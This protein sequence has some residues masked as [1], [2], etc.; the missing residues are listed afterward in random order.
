MHKPFPACFCYR[1]LPYG[2][3]IIIIII[4]IIIRQF[5]KRRGSAEAEGKGAEQNLDKS[6]AQKSSTAC[7]HSRHPISYGRILFFYW[8]FCVQFTR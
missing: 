4:I 8:I 3:L 1:L 7:S 5:I 6:P 2:L